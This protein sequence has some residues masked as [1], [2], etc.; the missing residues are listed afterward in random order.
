[1]DPTTKRC[2]C[3]DGFRGVNGKCVAIPGYLHQ[4]G[5]I[6]RWADGYRWAGP[7]IDY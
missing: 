1:M 7:N 3:K 4:N 6:Y 5:T 2:K